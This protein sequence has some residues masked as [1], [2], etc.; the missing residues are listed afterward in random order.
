MVFDFIKGS[1]ILA[2]FD[3][4]TPVNEGFQT[5]LEFSD[6]TIQSIL[7]VTKAK[8]LEE[9]YADSLALFVLLT[10]LVPQDP[11]YWYRAGISA[12]RCQNYPL[13]L[14]FYQEAIGLDPNLIGA[15]VF[16][17]EC[18]LKSDLRTEAEA[19]YLEAKRVG[20]MP[21]ID[22]SWKE[23]LDQMQMLLKR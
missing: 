4:K 19:A 3:F 1:E 16:S 10:A 22:A 2:D 9:S 21:E 14:K 7:T 5:L 15:W 17:V 8:Y 13:A 20:E 18:Y 6:S 11:T 12:H 23:M